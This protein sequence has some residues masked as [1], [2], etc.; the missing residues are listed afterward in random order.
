MPRR[1]RHCNPMNILI[2]LPLQWRRAT[3]ELRENYLNVKMPVRAVEPRVWWMQI[4]SFG[5]KN[6]YAPPPGTMIVE[7][8]RKL[9]QRVNL[10]PRVFIA[11][12]RFSFGDK[13]PGLM[14]LASL[15]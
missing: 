12:C 13:G 2:L 4:M 8:G 6:P 3:D 11:M 7:L 1:V 5:A 14:G 9:G 15:R 10:Q